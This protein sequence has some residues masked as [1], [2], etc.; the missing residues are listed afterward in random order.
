MTTTPTEGM[1][2][3]PRGVRRGPARPGALPAAALDDEHETDEEREAVAVARA[4]V[5]RGDL[6]PL[7]A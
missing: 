4:D 7:A 3:V 6:V 5:A 2:P 1:G